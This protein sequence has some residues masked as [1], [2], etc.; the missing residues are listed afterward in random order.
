MP[1]TADRDRKPFPED[2]C[3]SIGLAASGVLIGV[4]CDALL[5]LYVRV[6]LA[7]WLAMTG[8]SGFAE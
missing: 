1:R 5:L 4:T 7:G 2:N 6:E 8:P 3:I